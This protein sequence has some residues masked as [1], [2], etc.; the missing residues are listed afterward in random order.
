MV[1]MTARSFL[2]RK[3]C[4]PDQAQSRAITVIAAVKCSV[5]TSVCCQLLFLHCMVMNA[6]RCVAAWMQRHKGD[7]PDRHSSSAEVTGATN[8]QATRNSFVCSV[9]HFSH[10]GWQSTYL[11]KLQRHFD[12]YCRRTNPNTS[13]LWS[14]RGLH[15]HART[16]GACTALSNDASNPCTAYTLRS[17]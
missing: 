17:V 2:Q 14:L 1:T 6:E 15:H 3:L 10:A 9:F 4:R 7:K 11:T 13:S 5:G 8:K 16:H 12:E